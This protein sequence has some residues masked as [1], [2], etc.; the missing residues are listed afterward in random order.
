VIGIQMDSYS[1][2]IAQGLRSQMQSLDVVANNLANATTAGFKADHSFQ[3]TLSDV[4]QGGLAKSQNWTDFSQGSLK[5][6]GNASD[7][8]L[9]GPGLFAV[10]GKTG[11]LYTRNGNFSVSPAGEFV[12]PEGHK[13]QGSGGS[14]IK[15]D[16]A[17]PFAIGIDGT[18]SQ[19]GISAGQIA[20]VEFDGANALQKQGG[21]F[22]KATGGQAP[23]PSSSRIVQGS[24]ENSNVGA[25]E[26]SVEMIGIMRQFESLQKALSL[27]TEMDKRTIESTSRTTS[28]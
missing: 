24:L 14:T 10:T 21:S 20:V 17:R 9:D 25:A 3:L 1:N 13:L 19:D 8:A 15:V 27:H 11:P 23:K 26:S 4:Q 18:V 6:T 5:P 16:P 22:Y 12:T 7:L 28:G 2:S